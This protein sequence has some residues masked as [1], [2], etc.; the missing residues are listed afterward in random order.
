VLNLK[1]REGEISETVAGL[2]A[3]AQLLTGGGPLTITELYS[4]GSFYMRSPLFE[5]RLPGG[6]RWMKLDVAGAAAKLGIDP[7]AL[8]GGQADPGQYLEYLRAVGSMRATGSQT[9]RGV[10][11]TRYSGTIDLHKLPGLLP[12]SDRAAASG[13]IDQLA[14][15]LGASTLP[16]Q[17]W[18]DD[19]GMIRRLD[20]SMALAVAGQNGSLHV[21]EELFGFGPTPAIAAPAASEV[22]SV[23]SGLLGSL[24]SS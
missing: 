16:V 20:L 18:I 6:A 3:S 4:G 24:T 9:L 15:A 8:L 19:H 11:T 2:P 10:A 7:E 23:G 13:A 14:A 22:F 21:R 12:S 17:V 1:S 5:G